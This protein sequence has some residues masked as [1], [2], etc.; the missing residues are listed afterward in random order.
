MHHPLNTL[1]AHYCAVS[2]AVKSPRRAPRCSRDSAA[3]RTR[4]RSSSGESRLK[5]TAN[6]AANVWPLKKN[7]PVKTEALSDRWAGPGEELACRQ[8]PTGLARL[9]GANC[10]TLAA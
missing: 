1:V 10:E 9:L 4:I 5:I 8:V 6:V 7:I 2:P 3:P